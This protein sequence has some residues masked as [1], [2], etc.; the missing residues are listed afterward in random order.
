MKTFKTFNMKNEF[1]LDVEV[2]HPET[3]EPVTITVKGN[4]WYYPATR[5]DPED[6]GYEFDIVSDNVPEWITDSMI[7]DNLND[8][9]DEMIKEDEPDY[10]PQ[11]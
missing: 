1:L 6:S 4:S 11:D 10:E 9:W 5:E 7:E 3:D 8:M 2:Y